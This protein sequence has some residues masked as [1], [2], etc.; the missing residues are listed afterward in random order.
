MTDNGH[1][2]TMPAGLGSQHAKAVLGMVPDALDETSKNFW[3]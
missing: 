1:D 2:I 3:R